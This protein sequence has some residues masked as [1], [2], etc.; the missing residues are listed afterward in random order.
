MAKARREQLENMALSLG[1]DLKRDCKTAH[2][3][4]RRTLTWGAILPAIIP[5]KDEDLDEVLQIFAAR[6]KESGFT[7]I[8]YCKAMVPSEWLV[9]P[10]R[11][12]S[13]VHLRPLPG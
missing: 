12:G 4:K 11:F 2:N 13:H 8:E 6:L 7:K 5:G 3:L 10:V 1:S 9:A